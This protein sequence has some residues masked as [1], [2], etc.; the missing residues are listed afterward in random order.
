[1]MNHCCSL[2]LVPRSIYAWKKA[3]WSRF[4]EMPNAQCNKLLKEK[5][6]V[7]KRE[8]LLTSAIRIATAAA[9]PRGG[10]DT[11]PYWTPE[12][13]KIEKKIHSCKPSVSRDRLVA[14]R[15]EM[16]RQASHKRWETLCKNIAVAGC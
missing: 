10:R 9:V 2:A 7:H 4:R 11:T 5:T 15:R 1:M 6:G 3:K 8:R 13:D 12:L 16:P 14:H